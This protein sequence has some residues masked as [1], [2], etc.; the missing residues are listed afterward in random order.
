MPSPREQHL[1]GLEYLEAVTTLLQRVRSAHPTAGL[2]EAADLQWWWRIPRSSDTIAQLFW[3]QDGQPRAAVIATDWG[4]R[5][6]IDPLVMPDE[7]PDWISHVM[8]RG[9][10]HAD[11]LGLGSI[12]LEV[13]RSDEVLPGVLAGHGFA[14][15][16]GGLVE[17]WLAAD[18]RP[19]I[20]SLH[21]RYRL[22]SRRDTMQLPYHHIKRNHPDIEAR[23]RQTSLYRPDLDLVVHDSVGSVAAYGLFWYD[24]V[25]ATGL[26]EPMRTE[27]DHQR[28]G[29]ARH[30]LTTG[31]DLLAQAG[32]ER[33]KI[34]FEPDNPA[35][36][37]LYLS[38]GFEPVRQT[39]LYSRKDT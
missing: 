16:P 30:I 32:A 5:V 13:A 37:H 29:L 11:E 23:L 7:S 8:E 14:I 19:E 27:D 38:V 39:D 15:E 9:L 20:S 22:S 1:V 28:R 17:S 10:A 25:T 18:A 21:D 6:A 3:F 33:I 4:D 12:G 36:S 34:C 31:I 35:S 2:F 26:V 24:P